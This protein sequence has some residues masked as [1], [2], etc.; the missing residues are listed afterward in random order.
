VLSTL[1]QHHCDLIVKR[2]F[3]SGTVSADF[4]NV[5]YTFNFRYR[6]PWKWVVDL[7]TDPSL[8]D[9]IVWYPSQKFLHEDGRVTRLYD[10]YDTA[11]TWWEVQVR[12]THIH[13][14]Q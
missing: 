1:W 4:E 13:V 9:T 3:Q 2:Q 11:D 5:T 7:I 14:K 6:D 12:A 8:A 10:E